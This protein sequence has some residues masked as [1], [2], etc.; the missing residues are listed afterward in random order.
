MYAPKDL[1][2]NKDSLYEGIAQKKR[3]KDINRT[4]LYITMVFCF[5]AEYLQ[6]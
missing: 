4:R 6:S 2:V 5:H 3:K 1:I